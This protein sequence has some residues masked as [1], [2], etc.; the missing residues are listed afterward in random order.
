[1]KI[2][3]IVGCAVM[4]QPKWHVYHYV[5]CQS[6]SSVVDRARGPFTHILLVI[7]GTMQYK[8]LL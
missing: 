4:Q 5:T 7:F 8:G 3:Y 1:M 2:P 6:G